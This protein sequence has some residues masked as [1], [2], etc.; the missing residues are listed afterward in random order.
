[1]DCSNA[2]TWGSFA[3]VML[4]PLVPKPHGVAQVFAILQTLGRIEMY[5]GMLELQS[6]EKGICSA[7]A[8]KNGFLRTQTTET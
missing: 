3:P 8:Q 4:W 7:I 2:K 5:G 6:E 1:M